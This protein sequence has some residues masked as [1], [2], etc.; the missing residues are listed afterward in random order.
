MSEGSDLLVAALKNEGVERICGVPGAESQRSYPDPEA[1][2]RARYI[3]GIY[4]LLA[5]DE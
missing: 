3:R 1:F 5:H 4:D 2:E